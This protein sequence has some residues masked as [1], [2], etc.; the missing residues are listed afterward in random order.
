MKEQVRRVIATILEIPESSVN[1]LSSPDTHE[2]WDSV[3]HI[4]IILAIEQEFSLTFTDEEIVEM[5]SFEL[6]VEVIKEK[7]G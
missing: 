5:L 1:D 3:N 4:N 7:I 2:G 6:I